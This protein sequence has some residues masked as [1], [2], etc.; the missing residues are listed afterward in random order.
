[1]AAFAALAGL[2]CAQDYVEGVQAWRAERESNL[3][4]ED[5]WLAVAG[6]FWLEEGVN[7]FGTAAENDFVFPEGSVEDQA[8]EFEFRNGKVTMRLLDAPTEAVEMRPDTAE[9]PT[10]IKHGRVSFYVIQR[11]DRFGI[12]LIDP[13]SEFRQHFT[14]LNWYPV[15]E[16]FKITARFQAF[17]TP[18]TLTVPS[19][20][21]GTQE[22]SSPG[23]LEFELNGR[24][25]RLEPAESE[26]ELFLVF[27]DTTAG[28]TTYAGGRFLYTSLPENG[29]VELDFNKAYN[30]PCVFTP[31]A[32]CPLPPP[33]NR[34]DVPI[35]A[36][37]KSYEHDW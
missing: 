14:G 26:D 33:Q 29:V 17:E 23:I 21:G 18:H 27:R 9:N 35:E 5:G 1:M 8:G 16:E 12:R 4:A 34:L 24:T 28:D 3:Q 6:L 25:L 19:V 7:T 22:Y 36:G 32:T 11:G 20:I 13:E 31:Y 37:E 10:E 2:L 30:P 15:R